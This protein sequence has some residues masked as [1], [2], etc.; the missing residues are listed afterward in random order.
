M[1][2]SIGTEKA[3]V[4]VQYPFLIKTLNKVRIEGTYLKIIKATYK[5]PTTN[6]ILI[7]EKL[8]AFPMVTNKTGMSALTTVI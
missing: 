5:K 3:F 2:L 1:I 6:I 4:K 7:G 8:R